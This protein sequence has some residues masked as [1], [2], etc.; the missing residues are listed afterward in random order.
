LAGE[1]DRRRTIDMDLSALTRPLCTGQ[2]R[3][4]IPNRDSDR[5]DLNDDLAIS[6]RWAAGTDHAPTEDYEGT[7]V[8]QRC[9]HRPRVLTRCKKVACS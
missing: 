8:L 3:L 4:F 7:V 6:G 5:L 2:Q 9:G 1:P